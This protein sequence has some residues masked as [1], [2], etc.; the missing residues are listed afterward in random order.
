MSVAKEGLI[1]AA[2]EPRAGGV[3]IA[4][5]IPAYNEDRFIGSVVLKVRHYADVVLVIDD[6]SS[7]QTAAVAA[8]AGAEV[9]RHPANRGKAAAINTAFQWARER[10]VA[11]L[12]LIDGDGQHTPGE[13]PALVAPVQ[14]GQA[15]MV[16]GTRYGTVT[17]RIPRYRRA[18][19][20]VL[21]T[22]TNLISGVSVSDSQSGFR[23]FSSRAIQQMRFTS[24]RFALES[25]MQCIARSAGLRITEVPITAI[26]IEPA[27]RNPLRHGA[28]VVQA[29][30]TLLERR[31]PL[32]LLG[33]LGVFL[34][35][36]GL[37]LALHIT[38]L[39]AEQQKLA[40]GY[41][42]M[43]IMLIIVGILTAFVGII[44]HS[45]RTLLKDLRE[46]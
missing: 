3:P 29:L 39:Y 7:D 25:E 4:V 2:E 31:R 34:V 21:T 9:I 18:G 17:S 6:G 36:L 27:K 40:V 20:R 11:A 22:L 10:H 15:D 8:A 13:I 30:I 26:Y 37:L 33:S 16:I 23:A 1:A 32:F 19:Q 44:L 45:M 43:T 41:S 35:L 38:T 42:I 12:V 28:A 24:S 14:R 46:T 5:A